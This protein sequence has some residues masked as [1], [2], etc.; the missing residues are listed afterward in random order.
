MNRKEE[1]QLSRQMYNSVKCLIVD[2]DVIVAANMCVCEF[3]RICCQVRDGV[4]AKISTIFACMDVDVC[5]L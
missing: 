5:F 1:K 2:D 3:F 4:E